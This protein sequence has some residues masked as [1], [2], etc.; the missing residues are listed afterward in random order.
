MTVGPA[1]GRSAAGSSATDRSIA[2][3]SAADRSAVDGRPAP[4]AGQPD[5][6]PDRSGGSSSRHTATTVDRS[7]ARLSAAL[8]LGGVLVALAASAVSVLALLVGGGGVVAVAVGVLRGSRAALGVGVAGLFAGALLAGVLG[9]GPV[10]LLVAVAATAF[11]WDAGENA[12]GVG[13]QLGRAADTARA[14]LVH[15]GASAGLLTTAAGVGLLA[16]ALAGGGSPLALVALLLGAVLLVAA[17][18]E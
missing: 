10:R 3:R 14:E 9:G 16:F 5:G 6:S 17:L 11:A 18:R 2:D 7:P 4:S 1:T 13:E 12:I 8:A 15:A